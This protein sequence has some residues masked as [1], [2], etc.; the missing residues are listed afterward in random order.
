MANPTTGTTGTGLDSIIDMIWAD[1]DLNEHI[2]QA[3]I[4]GGTRAANRM[5]LILAEAIEAPGLFNDQLISISDIYAIN[6][7][8]RA[9]HLGAWTRHHGDDEWYGETGYHLVQNDGGST[10]LEY[11][12]LVN[13]VFDGIYHL[14]FE[15]HDGRVYNEDGD[16]NAT[17]SDLAHWMTYVMRGGKSFYFGTG[18]DDSVRG[19]ILDDTLLLAGGDDYGNG[20]GG[21]DIIRGGLGND[22][23]S[24]GD[25]HD[26]LFGQAGHDNLSG[27]NGHDRLVGDV[28]NNSLSGGD[29]NDNMHGNSGHDSLYGGNDDDVMRGGGG[30]DSLHGGLGNDWMDGGSGNDY[31]GR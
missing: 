24:G 7:Y 9:N 31:A 28:G 30:N 12:H 3:D 18:R 16:A 2:S 17:I 4:I 20:E 19:H 10:T 25:G 22:H 21:D 11:D 23:L 27:D 8:I 1:Q 29:G 14:G 15:I 13:T 5:N 26:R 6:A